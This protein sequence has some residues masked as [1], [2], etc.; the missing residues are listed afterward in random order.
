MAMK[1]AALTQGCKKLQRQRDAMNFAP[2]LA[3]PLLLILTGT[4]FASS[5]AQAQVIKPLR[6]CWTVFPLSIFEGQTLVR[7]SIVPARVDAPLR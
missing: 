4:S 2:V 3:A 7:G 1:H 5:P 6:E